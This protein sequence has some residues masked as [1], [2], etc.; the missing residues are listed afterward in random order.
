M[1]PAQLRERLKNV[2]AYAVTPFK[3]ED[4]FALD[5]EG[6]ARNLEFLTSHGVQVINVGGGTGEVEALSAQELESLAAVALEKTGDCALVIPTLPGNLAVARELAPRYAQLGARVALG[7]P[8]LIRNQTPADLEGVFQY[9]RLLS[10]ASDLALMPY[11]TQGWPAGFFERLAQLE[12]IVGIK[13]PCF[14]PHNLFRAIRRLGDRF[15][16]IGNKRHDPGVLHFRYQAGIQGFTAG[17]VNFAPEHE[18]EL[19]WA[20]LR[21]DWPRMVQIQEQLA[22]LERLR[23]AH[24]DAV[25]KV[26]LDLVG[27]AGGR[28]RPPRQDVTPE[29]RAAVAVELRRLGLEVRER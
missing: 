25:L 29:G 5:L 11:N 4:L 16:W 13:D 28:V 12:A 15:V 24:G 26:C 18:L 19:H 1:F 8:P 6:L 22:P 2:H 23:M 21:Q 27:L 20:A 7:M 14:E 9:Y 17:F 10:Q 3:R